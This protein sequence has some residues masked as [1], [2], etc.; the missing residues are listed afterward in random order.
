MVPP[1]R[2]LTRLASQGGRGVRRSNETILSFHRGIIEKRR[3][4]WVTII[5]WLVLRLFSA[6]ARLPR[7][8][9]ERRPMQTRWIPG[10][11]FK[12]NNFSGKSFRM[13][14]YREIVEERE[15]GN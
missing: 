15:R 6:H 2:L 9:E 7:I 10:I 11:T 13:A 5:A 14:V 8:D 4:G 12:N 1:I 3:R